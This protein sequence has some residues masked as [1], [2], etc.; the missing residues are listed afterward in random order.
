MLPSPKALFAGQW[1]AIMSGEVFQERLH[2]IVVAEAM[3]IETFI[4]IS[5]VS[6]YHFFEPQCINKNTNYAIPHG[7]SYINN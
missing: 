3:V 6:Y 2:T 1:R 4:I 5:A 7:F